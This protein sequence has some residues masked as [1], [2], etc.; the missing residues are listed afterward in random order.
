MPT[1]C[2]NEIN[3]NGHLALVYPARNWFCL[4][5]TF[6]V[7]SQPNHNRRKCKT[8]NKVNNA[9]FKTN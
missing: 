1:F 7:A 3:Q 5:P 9:V 8:R 4:M 2:S 6:W